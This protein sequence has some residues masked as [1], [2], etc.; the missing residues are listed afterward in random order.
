MAGGGSARRTAE[1]AIEAELDRIGQW[2][3]FLN[4]PS[5]KSRLMSRY[6]YEHWFLAHLYFDDLPVGK[7][8]ELVRSRTPPG[9]PIDLIVTRRPFEDPGVS[10]VYYR[11]RPV[12]ATL[13]SKTHM[14]YALNPARMARFQSWF[15]DEPYR[16]TTL[17]SHQPEVAGNPFVAFE[18]LPV[19]SRY[20]MMLDEA[21]F[22]VMGFIKGRSAVARWR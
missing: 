7:Y 10:R 16:V 9:Q 5:L 14:P 11:L 6:I 12:T 1:S 4:V 8:F 22:T 21:Q 19:R 20:R 18:Q 3:A 13:V 17:P 2:E 15:I